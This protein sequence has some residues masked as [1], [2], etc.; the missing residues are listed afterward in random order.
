LNGAAC[1]DIK[2]IFKDIKEQFEKHVDFPDESYY[3]LCSIWVIG[4]YFHRLFSAYPYI[5]LQGSVASGKTK[6]LTLISL[7]SFNAELTFNSTQAYIIR[8]IH[9]NHSTICIDEAEN[10]KGNGMLI[11][12]LNAGYRQGIYAGKVEKE[13]GAFKPKLFE[14]Y[15]P[16][17][18]ASIGSIK[19]SLASR[20]IKI[21]MQQSQNKEIENKEI[22]MNNPVFQK[23]RDKLYLLM[24]TKHKDIKR[25]YQAITD[26]EIK[27]RNWELWK[28]LLAMAKLID[29]KQ[30][31]LYAELKQ[32]AMENRVE[33]GDIGEQFRVN[34]KELIKK[35]PSKDSFYTTGRIIRFLNSN[36]ILKGI[37]GKS[38]STHL[39]TI[40]I[41]IRPI[42]KKINRKPV[43]GYYLRPEI[44]GNG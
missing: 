20:C 14:G 26:E 13:D 5:H 28:P 2:E 35:Y 18:F 36:P 3:L 12:M 15:S 29:N 31:L 40:S 22:D 19:K 39:K 8:A 33:K 27:A 6:T 25:A 38:L 10:L 44:F 37:N 16:K 23:I 1:P 43:R 34:I 41:D 17:V 42:Q 7:L 30:S 21:Q 11:S 4:T 32:L 24:L 9:N